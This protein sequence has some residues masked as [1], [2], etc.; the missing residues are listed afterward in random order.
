LM[1][2][3]AQVIGNDAAITFAG[4]S[5]NFELNTMLPLIAYDLLQSMQILT[6]AASAFEEKCVRGL[7]A[8]EERCRETLDRSLALA[9]ALV[10]RLGYDTAAK[11]AQDAYANG[12]TIR[13]AALEK[14]LMKA[15]ELDALLDPAKMIGNPEANR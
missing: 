11:L 13:Q 12:K 5:G 7:S 3:C 10:P 8:D 1:M 15:E 6:G 2:A 9:T 14:G 4:A